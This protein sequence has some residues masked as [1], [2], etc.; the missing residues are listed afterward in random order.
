MVKY[1]HEV[2]TTDETNHRKYRPG[3]V[4]SLLLWHPPIATLTP[5]LPQHPCEGD[6]YWTISV[7]GHSLGGGIASIVG[8]TL[9]L[10]V[11]V[12]G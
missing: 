12:R 10:S 7:A 2:I 8:S 3:K 1:V 11:W 4:P 9:G 6:D 5:T